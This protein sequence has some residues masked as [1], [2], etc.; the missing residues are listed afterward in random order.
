MIP[1]KKLQKGV[2]ILCSHPRISIRCNSYMED[3]FS[4]KTKH[5]RYVLSIGKKQSKK[6]KWSKD[7][8]CNLSWQMSGTY[9]FDLLAQLH[10]HLRRKHSQHCW[11]TLS[12]K[13]KV[14]AVVFK[15]SLIQQS[16]PE[17]LLYSRAW[18]ECEEQAAWHTPVQFSSYFFA[19]TKPTSPQNCELPPETKTWVSNADMHSCW[20]TNMK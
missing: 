5:L 15:G 4:E 1:L 9:W 3:F 14:T 2:K 16:A 11:A 20:N 10:T 7:P 17:I 19:Q 12:N 13:L 8:L 18:E 6:Q